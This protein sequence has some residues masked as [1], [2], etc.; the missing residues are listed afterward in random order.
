MA[1]R[2]CL[3]ALATAAARH[4]AAAI[5][6]F[7]LLRRRP[8]LAAHANAPMVHLVVDLA[9]DDLAAAVNRTAFEP[10]LAR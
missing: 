1:V 5:A 10:G 4:P 6:L 7:P 8:A 3:I 9:P 2:R